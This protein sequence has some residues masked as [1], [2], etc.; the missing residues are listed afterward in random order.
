MKLHEPF[1]FRGR[2]AVTKLD[3]LDAE[4][5]GRVLAQHVGHFALHQTNTNGEHLLARDMLGVHKLFFAVTRDGRVDASNYLFD[6]LRAGH[7]LE[8]VFSVPSGHYVRIQPRQRRYSLVRW[9]RLEFDTHAED[10]GPAPQLD[11][12][13][14]NI[15][16]ALDRT[17]EMIAPRIAGRPV[18]VALSGGLD[19]SSIAALAREHFDAVT[20]VTFA[21]CDQGETS[22]STDL[23]YARRV[24]ADLGLPMVEVLVEPRELLELI[25]DVLVYG[26]DWRD[27]NVHCGLVNAAIGRALAALHP[28]GPRP[29]VLTGDTMNELVADYSPVELQGR[30]YYGLPV[31]DRGR[32]RRFLVRGLDSG[33]R[34][35]GIFARFGVQTLQPYAICAREFAA[36]PH[37]LACAVGSKA[38]SMRAVMED[39]VPDYVYERPKVR[40][41]V[42]SDGA[43][44]GTLAMLIERG[45]DQAHLQRRFSKLLSI[46][47]VAMRN[48]LRAG[49]YRFSTVFPERV[50]GRPR[51]QSN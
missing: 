45:I 13:A 32:I 27:F 33:D 2:H 42:A 24:A 17:F 38:V 16:A 22:K 50:N 37:E 4:D 43:P 35:V 19:S 20:A 11:R 31:I 29:V 46:D 47:P 14:K 30:E 48:L 12:L 39:A 15:R 21:V 3:L 51:P 10:P 7:A 41:Q 49:F 34:E 1:L 6:V 9:G 23:M 40:A 36:L 18:Y 25:D 44:G 8:N 28:A 26:Q 5:P